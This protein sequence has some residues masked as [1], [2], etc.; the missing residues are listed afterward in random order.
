MKFKPIYLIF[1]MLGLLAACSDD[2]QPE[3]EVDDN[4]ETEDAPVVIS[5]GTVC[6]LKATNLTTELPAYLQSQIQSRLTN[7]GS[8]L[9]NESQIVIATTKQLTDNDAS[10]LDAYSRGATLLFVDTDKAS[11]MSWLD[12]HSIEYCGD[13]DDFEDLHAIYAFNN[14]H[15]Y[16]LFDDFVD[17]QDSDELEMFP[18]RFDSVVDW[19]N[20]YADPAVAPNAGA[21]GSQRALQAATRDGK[22]YDIARTFGSQ[23]ITHNYALSLKDKEIA[24]VAASKPDRLTKSSSIDVTF[25][26]YPLYSHKSNGSSWGDYYIVEGYVNAHNAGMYNG[27]WTNRHGGVYA[28][29]CGFYMSKL[30]FSASLNAGGKAVKF[31]V[32]GTPVPQTSTSSTSYSSGFSWSIG[33][34]ISGKCDTTGPGGEVGIN[35]SCSWNNSETREL[36]DVTIRRDTPNGS[37]H[38][39]YTI[40]N[41]PHTSN[42]CKHLTV[43]DVAQAD[44]EC[45]HTWIWWVPETAADDESQFSATFRIEPEY[46]SYKWYSS[47]ADFGTKKWTD[48]LGES[49]KEFTVTLA[50]PSRKSK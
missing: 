8:T 36:Q 2:N 34:N 12:S 43:P 20:R 7:T 17:P 50:R 49:A 41:L 10:L 5:D 38:W 35:G 29:L 6:H 14:R 4:T 42:G 45:N 46:T 13:R 21:D 15:C 30:D 39:T 32:G 31:P 18:V 48:A 28:R 1:M 24:H 26:V 22:E 33:G 3:T 40:N 23:V 27:K 9:A 25:T 44:L 37:I 47:A 11:L 16:L 19:L